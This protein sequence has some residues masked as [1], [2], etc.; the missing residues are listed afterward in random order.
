MSGCRRLIALGLIGPAMA[1]A[2]TVA[3]QVDFS[4]DRRPIDPRIYGANFADSAQLVEPGFTVQRHGGNS[5]SR[6]NW[7]AD[8]HNT[9]SDYF[10]QNIPDGDGSNLPQNSTV[11]QLLAATLAAGREPILTIGTIGWTPDPQRVK[12]WGYSQALYG[13]QTLDECRFYD[14]N[15]P[16]WCTADSGNGLCNPAA[17]TTG[18]CIGGEIVGNNPDDTSFATDASWAAAWVSHLVGRHGSA[19]NGGVRLYALDNEP[20]LWNSTHRDVHPQ[21]ASYDEIWQKTVAYATAIKAADPGAQV[22]GPVTWGYCDLFGSAVDNC[23]EGPD[24]QAHGGLPFVQWYLRQVCQHQVS[25]GVRLVDYLDLHYYP[26]GEGVVD[27]G[28]NTGFSESA[29]VSARRLRSLKELHDPNWV[30][31]S[32]IADLGDFDANHYSKPQ[33]LPRV[34][35]WIAQECPD[36]KL[37]ITEYNWGAD[38]GASS[39]LAQAEALAIFAREG[40]DLATRWVAPAAG[41]L[42]ERAYRLYLNY[43]GAGS[44]VEGWSTRAI[45]ADID[46]LGS[47]AVDLPGQRRMLLLFNKATT[48][49]TVAISLNVAVQGNWQL[50]SFSAGSDVAQ[51]GQ[52]TIAGSSL[53]LAD[54]P[55]RRAFLLVLPAG[56]GADAL[57]SNG[58]ES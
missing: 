26:Q 15:P 4:A 52:G 38:S 42:V 20:M 18:F 11:N 2:A 21:P 45:S 10:Y 5:T 28:N 57:F 12:K 58:F 41:S 55:A 16:F 51:V 36:M 13:A 43:D 7:Q 19:S 47:Y 31:E 50:Y 17:N 14:P 37:A 8:V 25:N 46:Q 23:A 6:Y 29:A 9:A 39:A 56:S 34:R 35:A 44:R 49:T 30:S 3:V 40:V 32:W 1:T 53:S 24:R 33:L 27:F 54:L 48:T 22:L